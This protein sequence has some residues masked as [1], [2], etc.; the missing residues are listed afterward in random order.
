MTAIYAAFNRHN[1][2]CQ[3]PAPAN[4]GCASGPTAAPAHFA[5]PG[6]GSVDL[7][8]STVSGATEYW[9]MKTEGFAGCNFGK[10]KI[11][12]VTGTSYT[13]NEVGNGRQYC[14]SV[15]AA[16]ASSACYTPG[17]TCSCVTPACTAPGNSP[18]AVGPGEG[19]TGVDFLPSLDWTDVADTQYEV[20]I[21]TDAA[22]TTV[23]QGAQGL[24]SSDWRV[25]SSLQPDTTYYW[26]ARAITNCGGA[27]AWSSAG[28]FTTRGCIALSAPTGS[29]PANGATNVAYTPALDWNDVQLAGAYEVQVALDSSFVNMVA[30][31]LNLSSSTWTVSPPLSP[32]TTYYWRTR[33]KDVCGQ[34]AYTTASFTTANL[35]TPSSATFNA[36]YQAPYCASGCGCDTVTLVRGRGTTSGGGFEKNMPNTINDSCLDGNS[37]IFHVDESI[38]KLVVRSV[39]RSTIA[40]GTALKLDVTVWCQSATDKVDLYYTTNAA[41][42]SWSPLA[43]GLAC[44][45]SGAK[46]FTHNFNAGSTAGAHAI[47]AQIRYGG[48]VGTCIAGNYNE[49]DDMVFTVVAPLAQADSP[50]PAVQG[51]SVLKR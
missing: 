3:T 20:Q 42:P 35:C 24:V 9:V 40:P 17:S 49:R 2:A 6:E 19:S 32:N 37:G 22:F 46:V 4:S 18:T 36:N 50:S 15:V 27:S 14:Y 29:N 41:S 25:A 13:D 8:W 21:A 26:R 38:D 33:A 44:T 47:R 1:I 31:N 28:S 7:S 10:A 16:G 5:T 23:V 48:L 34:S 12:T 39:D 11:A 43:T 51:R 30:S 45:G